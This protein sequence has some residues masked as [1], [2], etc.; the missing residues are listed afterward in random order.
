MV[1]KFYD[2]ITRE[3]SYKDTFGFIKKNIDY[4]KGSFFAGLAGALVGA[5]NYNE[6]IQYAFSSGSKEA[7]KALLIGTTNISLCRKIATE[8]ENKAKAITLATIVPATL[9]IILTYGVHAY[10]K[11]TPYPAKSTAPAVLANYPFFL[12]LAIRE[13][14]LKEKRGQE[15]KLGEISDAK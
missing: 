1:N 12:A 6:G 5:L 15:S 13:R 7:A 9:G 4:K 3:I 11:G 2:L 10:I 8:V 14:K